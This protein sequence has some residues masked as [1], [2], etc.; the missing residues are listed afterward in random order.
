MVLIWC[1]KVQI[2]GPTGPKISHGLVLE[3]FQRGN[4]LGQP[5]YICIYVYL[6]MN[7]YINVEISIDNWFVIIACD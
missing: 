5:V 7:I 3:K 1:K 4:F 2:S 6:Y